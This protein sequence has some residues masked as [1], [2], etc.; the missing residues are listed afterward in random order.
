VPALH[1]AVEAI[2]PAAGLLSAVVPLLADAVVGV[3]AGA[4]VLA[5]VAVFRK[6][7][8]RG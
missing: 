6:I 8:A 3:A 2:T 1:H 4:F 7:G 5:A